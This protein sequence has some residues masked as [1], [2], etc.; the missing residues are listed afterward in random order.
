M[1]IQ[2]HDTW[3]K[4]KDGLMHFDVA[5]EDKKGNN[6]K[7]A[8]ESATKWLRSIG[9]DKAKITDKECEF[10]HTEEAAEKVES[11][12]KRDGFFIIKISGCP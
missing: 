9:E 2:I 8:I 11:N 10:C 5:I 7:L 12:I 3:I 4:G 6:N 1:Q